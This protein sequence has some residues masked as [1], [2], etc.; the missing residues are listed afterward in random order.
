MA[1]RAQKDFQEC[2]TNHGQNL[3]TLA[4][5]SLDHTSEHQRSALSLQAAVW[6]SQLASVKLSYW[7]GDFASNLV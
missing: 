7:R 3:V 2:T 1:H 4:T 6:T 5:Y